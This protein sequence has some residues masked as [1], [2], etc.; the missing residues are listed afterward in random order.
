MQV[1]IKRLKLKFPKSHG[2]NQTSN[3][4]EL[5]AIELKV[6]TDNVPQNASPNFRCSYSSLSTSELSLRKL[7]VFIDM[8]VLSIKVLLFGF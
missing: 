6:A 2:Q 8:F 3:I 1:E 4:K 7:S 5:R